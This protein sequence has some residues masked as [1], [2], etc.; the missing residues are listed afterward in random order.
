[1]FDYTD[2]LI[3][4]MIMID[5]WGKIDANLKDSLERGLKQI[6]K[7]EFKPHAQVFKQLKKKY[8]VKLNLQTK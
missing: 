5:N 3:T 4:Q 7:K 2:C 6:E 8:A 1:M